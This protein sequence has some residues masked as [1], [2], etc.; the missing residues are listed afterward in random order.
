MHGSLQQTLGA[1][2][3]GR[4]QSFQVPGLAGSFLNTAKLGPDYR[5]PQPQ[6]NRVLG[7]ALL[8]GWEGWLGAEWGAGWGWWGG[9]SQA[10]WR[11]GQPGVHLPPSPA[12]RAA[13]LGEAWLQ[14]GSVS[15]ASTHPCNRGCQC[16]QLGGRLRQRGRW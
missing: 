15:T 8:N 2:S 14:V 7:I 4:G 11:G 16:A 1:A 9:I 6:G 5:S 12:G 13:T 3:P 10:T